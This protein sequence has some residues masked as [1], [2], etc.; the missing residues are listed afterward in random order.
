MNS[1]KAFN[2]FCYIYGRYVII[3]SLRK[4]SPDVAEVYRQY[5]DQSVV[6]N[7]DW[8][9]SIVCTGCLL[10]LNQW[11][12]GEIDC[13][14]F[15]VPMIWM[16]FDLHDANQCYACVNYVFGTNRNKARSLLYKPTKFAPLPLPHSEHIPIPKRLCPTEQVSLTCETVGESSGSVYEPSN[17]TAGCNHIEISQNRLDIMTRRLKLSQRVNSFSPINSNLW[18]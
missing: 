10:K 18:C 1:C 9:P 17:V 4:I 7:V 8:A 15:G 2:T 6:Y 13:M 16:N 5:F 14:P 12:K 3:T 11:A